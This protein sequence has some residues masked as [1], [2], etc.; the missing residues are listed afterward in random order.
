[1]LPPHRYY[2]LH[3][4]QRALAWVFDRYADL[5]DDADRRFL[6]DFAALPQASQAL[7]V[8]M[9]MRRGPWF[10]SSRLVYEEIPAIEAAAA[11][12]LALG[13]LDAAA[14]MTLDELFGLLTKPELVRLALLP[15]A[16]KP[17]ARK[18]EL[19]ETLRPVYADARPYRGWNP[20]S[21]EAVWRVTVG[22][23]CERLRL[24]FF[25]NLHQDWS[26][27]VLADLGVFQYE[28]VPF[29]GASRAFQTRA[30]VDCYL[31]LHACRQALD[32][33]ADVDVL[34][35]A[36][37]DCA[38][39]NAWLE[40][41]RAKVL[42][43]IG[44]ACERAQDWEAA[45]RVYACCDYPGARHRRIRVYERMQRFED[46]MALAL[47]SASAPES[48][49]ESQRVA[50]MMPRLR[51]GLGQGAPARAAAPVVP[52]TDL[53]LARPGQPLSV[54]YVARDHLHDDDAPVHY[55]ENALIN[56]LFGLLC[57]PAVFAPLPGA[58]FHPFQ[59]G[60]ADLDAPDF[61]ARRQAHFEDCLAQLDTSAYRDVILRRYAE[62]FGVQSP[63]V[64]WGALSEPLL[65]QALDCLPA[66]HLKLFFA[67]LLR[68]VKA[69]R[70]GLPDLVRFWPAERR[71]ELIEV[72]GPGDKLQDNQ[73]RWLQYCVAHGMPVRVCHVS[74]LEGAA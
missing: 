51:R 8:R 4:F 5:L 14:P 72:K 36:A 47:Q 41:R 40:K 2:Y 52:R 60:P 16:A 13:W 65:A 54:E 39:G 43:R 62:K 31:A 35:R 63:F 58:F 71:Y 42:L 69:N 23:R 1:M 38:S 10:R 61:Y 28:A 64:F 57:W 33:G 37:Q 59:R 46:A 44:Q 15:A 49:E 45:Q 55:V 25:G 66:A 11:P 34:L 3:N 21:I 18:A 32:Q 53:A 56:S 30:D 50:R 48:E 70:T 19:L 67:R 6:A 73:I 22:D 20:D 17:A 68:D 27:F 24:M 74:W 29:D 7:M 9:L 12:L 26:E